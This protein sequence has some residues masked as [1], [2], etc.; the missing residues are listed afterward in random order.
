VT[1]VLVHVVSI[2]ERT[3]LLDHENYLP[4]FQDCVKRFG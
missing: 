3:I 4:G 2:Q 1:A